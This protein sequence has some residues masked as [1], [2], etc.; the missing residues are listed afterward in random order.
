MH[1]IIHLPV[2][3]VPQAAA[4]LAYLQAAGL[5]YH[6]EDLAE[7]CLDRQL[8]DG[9]ITP[10]DATALNARMQEAYTLDWPEPYGCPCGYLMQFEYSRRYLGNETP[11]PPSDA[12]Q[13]KEYTA[14]C[15]MK[16]GNGTIWISSSE[17]TN[18]EQA[19]ANAIAECAEDWQCDPADIHCL[20]IA[21]G[22]VEIL[23]WN[24]L[25]Q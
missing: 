14:W 8:A 10:A 17:A 15:C 19:Q 5:S 4:L 12:P 22:D 16:E 6:C 25:E 23:H 20:G 9:T 11:A 1:P 21:A 7:D 13:E 24:D 3:T 2:T 18:P